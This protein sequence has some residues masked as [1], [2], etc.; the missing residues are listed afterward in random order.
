MLKTGLSAFPALFL[1]VVIL[2]LL[3]AGVM[4]ATEVGVIA[5]LWA[6]G[7]GMFVHREMN[8]R[9]FY[10]DMVDCAIDVGIIVFLVSVA[11]PV[12]WV[13]LA[14]Q[15]PQHLVS[16]IV[17]NISHQWQ[18]FLLVNVG[19][20]VAGCLLE[21]VPSILILAPL[22]TPLFAAMGVDPIHG[23][24]IIML[25]LLL[26]TAAPPMGILVFVSASVARFPANKIFKE[27]VPFVIACY[28]VLLVVTFVPDT[29]LGL[30]KW[31]G[32]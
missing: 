3:R 23:G 21:V 7:V 27:C 19:A 18:L 13:L 1:V 20:F 22:L 30:W 5:V 11:Q 15:T 16:L 17:P 14:D 25:N 29:A 6:F 2:G 10:T 12:A 9:V 8:W 4:T 31:L 26:A 24:I 28:V 32:Q